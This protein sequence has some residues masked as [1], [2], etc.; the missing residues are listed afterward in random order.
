MTANLTGTSLL[1]FV[2]NEKSSY[3][4]ELKQWANEAKTQPV[5]WPTG[6]WKMTIF[7]STG[8]LL[9]I[10]QGAAMSINGNVFTIYK[11]HLQNSL[12]AGK[13]GYNIRCDF[14]DG[15]NIYPFEGTISIEK[16]VG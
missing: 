8:V 10:T 13:Y 7:D 6:V 4:I 11:T 12:A 5:D 14:N 2:L 16:K 1:N 3:N 9:V 15:T